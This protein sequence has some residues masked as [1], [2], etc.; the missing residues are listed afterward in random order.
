MYF[1]LMNAEQKSQ[2]RRLEILEEPESIL[3]AYLQEIG[4]Y[5]LFVNQPKE[6]REA[7]LQRRVSAGMMPL[8]VQM[9]WGLPERTRD[10][11]TAAD[12]EAGRK[13]V[14][15]DFAFGSEA[16]WAQYQRSVCFVNDR[17]LWMRSKVP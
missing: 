4:V 7:V 10:V 9:A 8:Q 15:W 14:I 6:V 12:T 17:V 2:F 1:N 5:Q 16:G 11:S 3:L 13:R